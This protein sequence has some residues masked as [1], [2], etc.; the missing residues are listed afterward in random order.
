[1]G[2]AKRRGT[3]S[4]RQMQAIQRQLNEERERNETVRTQFVED[5]KRSKALMALSFASMA[6]PR[7]K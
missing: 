7:P 4:E 3:F 2:Q 1:M 6:L 5:P